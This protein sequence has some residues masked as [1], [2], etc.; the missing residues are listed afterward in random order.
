MVS[1]RRYIYDQH[2]VHFH[3]ELSR[4]KGIGNNIIA[5]I[6]ILLSLRNTHKIL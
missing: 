2:S 5:I 6:V 3:K 4:E 1:G